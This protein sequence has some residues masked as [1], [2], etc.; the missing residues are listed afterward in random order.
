MI[1]YAEGHGFLE[2]L[3]LDGVLLLTHDVGDLGFE[4]RE[5]LA[6]VSDRQIR[7]GLG[8]P[9][10][11]AL[12]AGLVYCSITGYGME[13]EDADTPGYDI[14]A[15][16]A[17]SGWTAD[18]PR[19]WFVPSG[20]GTLGYALPASI[21][22]KVAR[23]DVPSIAVIGD[24]GVMFT[25]QD[26]MTAVQENISSIVVVFNDEGY[27]VERRHQDHLYGRRSGVDIRPPDFVALAQAF[28][29][30]AAYFGDFSRTGVNA[31]VMPGKRIGTYSCVGA[32]VVVYE[33]I[34]DRE[35]ITLRQD[36]ERKKWGP[37]QYG[38]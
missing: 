38:W 23:S 29:A 18:R 34:P 3:G 10:L 14:A 16:W 9:A 22:A 35:L 15:F 25:I 33:D 1:A 11:R 17:R 4:H 7:L 12:N 8:E 2:L 24:A 21:G 30:N 5:P 13:G 36:L 6:V 28:G 32:G 19:T 20:F 26:L 27:G 31:I 37:E